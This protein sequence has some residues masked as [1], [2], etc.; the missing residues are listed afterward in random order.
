MHMSV[1][2]R[3]E[4]VCS[5]CVCGWSLNWGESG[6]MCVYAVWSDGS[7]STC[8][9]ISS[10]QLDLGWIH[11]RTQ[12]PLINS[13]SYTQLGQESMG[14]IQCLPWSVYSKEES[15]QTFL[16]LQSAGLCLAAGCGVKQNCSFPPVSVPPPPQLPC[17][18]L[19]HVPSSV[20]LSA[21]LPLI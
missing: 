17:T 13:H 18:L 6:C 8:F 16:F 15:K 9:H 5:L 20:T 7:V 4:G 21:Q 11:Y 1:C 10:S 12:T 2:L 14:S 19:L 3:M